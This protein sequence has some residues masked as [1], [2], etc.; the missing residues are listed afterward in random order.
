VAK[1]VREAD[2]GF[3]VPPGDPKAFAAAVKT[4]FDNLDLRK[5]MGENA[6]QFVEKKDFKKKAFQDYRQVFNEAMGLS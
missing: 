2:A 6:R 3:V 1:L 5:Q 4:L